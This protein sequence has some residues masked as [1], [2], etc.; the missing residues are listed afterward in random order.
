MP[1]YPNS[2]QNLRP[3]LEVVMDHDEILSL[4]DQILGRYGLTTLADGRSGGHFIKGTP[5]APGV[6]VGQA[7]VIQSIE[8]L[9]RIRPDSILICSRMSPV[10]SSVFPV[11]RGIISERGGI[12]STTA[13]VARES[14][15]PVVT[16]VRSARRIISDGD[17][18]KINGTD[19]SVQIVL[20]HSS[21]V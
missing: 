2:H 5:V 13:T 3:E 8:D 14:E 18:I 7:V 20:K 4:I 1:D 15:L 11:V 12:L 9:Q 21:E 6:A 19:G 16:G 17:L 10:Y